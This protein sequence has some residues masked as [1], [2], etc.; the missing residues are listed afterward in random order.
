[1]DAVLCDE[2]LQEILRR[3]PPS[4]YPAA[5]LVSRRWFAVLRSSLSSLSLRLPGAS[6]TSSW[7]PRPLSSVRPLTF[8]WLIRFHSLREFSVL[9]CSGSSV[10]A[11][12][13][14]ADDGAVEAAA[15][16]DG[17]G[18]GDEIEE[19]EGKG[20]ALEVLSLT[21]IRGGNHGFG[22]LW[23]RCCNLRRLQL[24]GC[25][26]TGDGPA[27]RSFARCL[28]NLQELELR[29]CRAIADVVLLLIAEHCRCLATLILYDGGSRDGLHRFIRRCGSGLRTLDLR[30]P[31]DLNNGHLVAVAENFQF[32]SCLRLQSCCLITGEGLRSLGRAAAGAAIEELVLVNCDVVEREPGL[33]TFLGQ[34]LRR[35]RRLDLSHNEMLLDKE[36]SSMLAS[37]CNLVDIKLRG[38]KFLTDASVLSM[39]RFCGLLETVD[40]TRCLGITAK[41]VEFLILNSP[42]LR[43]IHVEESKISDSASSWA[44]RRVIQGLFQSFLAIE[45]PCKED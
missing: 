43:Q 38:C 36:L 5:S 13:S 42:R 30:L 19:E 18:V 10:T 6:S 41:A 8:R 40:I 1:M 24:R 15:V 7:L 37:C 20:L 23:R 12:A 9:D 32:L 45:C 21:G 35:L 22:W 31:L 33:L 16:D 39:F 14:V 3:L 34:H 2:L 25:E 44:S 28:P 29:T 17:A 11:Q 26:A 27:S 4:A